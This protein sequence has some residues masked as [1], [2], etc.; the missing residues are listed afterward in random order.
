V[1]KGKLGKDSISTFA[2]GV[3]SMVLPSDD[4]E[5]LFKQYAVGENLGAG[6]CDEEWL[7]VWLDETYDRILDMEKWGVE[8]EKTPDGTFERKEM[9]WKIPM[10]MF[11]GPQMMKAMAKKVIGSTIQVVGHTMITDLLTKSGKLGEEVIGAVGFDVRT[12]QF[13]VFNA[14]S[15]VLAAGGCAFKGRFAC[16]RFQTGES[17]AMAYRGGAKLGLFEVGT[18]FHTTAAD[19]DAQGL[20]M[21][22]G[23][24]GQFVN[25]KGE[26]FMLD[27][28]PELEDHASMARVSESSAMEVR[29]GKGPIYLDMTRFTP[30]DVKKLRTVLPIAT[31]ILERAG[32][33]AGDR[34]LKKVQWCP[35]F[36]GTIGRSGGVIANIECK[37]S[38][39]GL[40]ACGDAMARSPSGPAGLAGAAVTGARA[41]I[42]AAEYAKEA[43]KPQIEKEQI[44]NLRRFAFAPLEREHGIEPDHIIIEINEVF[45]PYEVTVISR[46]DRM[47][48][49]IREIE[50]MRDEE[51]PLLYASDVHYL[52]LANEVRSMVLLAEM[53]LRL[54]LLRTESREGCLREDYPYEDNVNWL[55]NTRLKQENGK[56]K[57]WTE[58]IP[59]DR[60]KVKPKREKYLHPVFEVATRKGIRWG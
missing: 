57:L 59:V 9:R 4:K 16:H 34:I 20:N 39:L 28:D 18:I 55:K 25:A 8:W 12:G 32:V 21:F 6:L 29:A 14:K 33:L 53:Y 50:R 45:A 49:A 47:E 44:E 5:A 3:F 24:G 27:Y 60:Y 31:M 46:G 26:R 36:Y 42:F 52:R 22:V 40:Y 51:V 1:S 58:D 19:F 2:A 38:L 37:T 41:G 35:V 23:L 11:R 30:E 43:E 15:T 7:N 13:K 56:M 54:R 17:Y 48:K 10:G